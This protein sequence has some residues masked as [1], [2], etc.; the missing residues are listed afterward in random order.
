MLDKHLIA[1]TRPQA[2]VEN[3]LYWEDYR[4]TVLGARL[5]RL[6]K[7]DKKQFRDSATQAV[8]FRDMPKQTFRVERGAKAAVVDTGVC[9]LILGK[10]R[11]QVCVEVNGERIKVDNTGNLLGTYRTLDN[12][13][14]EVYKKPWNHADDPYTI[15]LENGVC[16][17]SGV[18][19]IEDNSLTLGEDGQVKNERA[20]GTDEYIFVYGKDYLGAVKALYTITGYPPLVPRF[21]LGNWWSRY[22]V[23]TEEE[24]LRVLAAFEEREIPLTV[25]TVD[26]DWHDSEGVEEWLK[27][28]LPEKFYPE[29]VGTPAVNYG[30][31]GYTWN[32]ELFPDPERFLKKVQEKGLKITLNLHPSDGVRFWEEKYED[33]AKVMGFDPMTK[34]QVPF[35]FTDERFLNAYFSILHRPLEKQGVDFWWVDWQQ[36]DIPWGEEGAKYDPLWALN[37]YHYLDNAD[38]HA[39]PLLLSRYAGLGS[40]RYPLGFSGDTYITWDTLAY[41][42]Y[43]T[44][45]ASNIGYT[46][47]SHDIGGHQQGEKSDE[48]YLRQVQ[49]GVF[50]PINRLHCTNAD[51]MTKEP[52]AYLQGTG[53]IA[54]AFLRFRHRLIPYL[55]TAA[56]A[57]AKEGIPLVQPLYYRWQEQAAYDH[58]TEYLFGSQLLVLPV[59]QK[60]KRNGYA[61]VQAWLPEGSWTDIF[62]GTR[63]DAPKGGKKCTLHRTLESIPVLIKSGGILPLSMDKG[64]G[65]DNPENLELWSYAGNG[66][67]T[68]YEDGKEQGNVGEHFTKFVAK[69][70]QT[71][72]VRMQILTI[73]PSGDK[74][75][76]PKNR[77]LTVRFPDVPLSAKLRL[78]EEGKEVKTEGYLTDCPALRF[79]VRPDRRYYLQAEYPLQE[80]LTRWKERAERVLLLAEGHNEN[81]RAFARELRACRTEKEF[82]TQIKKCPLPKP[83]PQLLKE[84]L[85]L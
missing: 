42:P 24:Y 31:T 78:F 65:C 41:L 35:A 81:K 29:Y 16:S 74:H 83:I 76:L 17:T 61:E 62:T 67:Y 18:A 48:L 66:E 52:W 26:M 15:S 73:T 19:A 59:T 44:A 30:W 72:G 39:T 70:T 56:W 46:W 3:I 51:T 55:Y 1:R 50:S 49:Y 57:T 9:K 28:T 4:V 47:W 63:Y 45:T 80:N 8:W 36:P 38:G 14:G 84:E 77:L 5:F 6:E 82:L 85:G 12:C 11:G 20:E 68:L 64:N 23:Y 43:F 25:A 7:S 69:Q 2:N 58:K 10:D 79:T 32:K 71:E 54:E 13:D 34:R 33:M 75:I 60:S 40:H 21:A 37:H 22:H 27:N 53:K